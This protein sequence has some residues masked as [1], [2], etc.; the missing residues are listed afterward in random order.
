M[1]VGSRG[2]REG[3]KGGVTGDISNTLNNKALKIK[4]K[5]EMVGFFI[6]SCFY[7]IRR[8]LQYF[9]VV[10][11]NKIWVEKPHYH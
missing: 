1:V 5:D 3:V 9:F 8:F 11:E 6:Y 10:L 4:N 7:K 2:R